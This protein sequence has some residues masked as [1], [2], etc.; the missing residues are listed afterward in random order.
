MIIITDA[1]CH[2]NTYHTY[3]DTYPGGDPNGID[4]EEYIYII[5]KKGIDLSV[6]DIQKNTE[7]MYDIFSKIYEDARGKPMNR[8]KLG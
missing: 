3:S 8:L 6:I 2:G 1:P 4:I 5:G 7:K